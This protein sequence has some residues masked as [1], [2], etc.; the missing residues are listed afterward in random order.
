MP[1]KSASRVK[2]SKEEN[3]DEEQSSQDQEVT[4][5]KRKNIS[6]EGDTSLI[7]WS[8]YV[9]TVWK[10]KKNN[11]SKPSKR[12]NLNRQKKQES[13]LVSSWLR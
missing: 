2:K 12:A 9:L 13:Q 4:Q 7:R 10:T 6:T 8:K 11:L 3:M 5:K 1:R